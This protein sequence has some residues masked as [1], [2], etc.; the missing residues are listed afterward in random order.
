MVRESTAGTAERCVRILVEVRWEVLNRG[1]DLRTGSVGVGLGWV[2]LVN[3]LKRIISLGLHCVF[4][5]SPRT[6]II[7][8]DIDLKQLFILYLLQHRPKKFSKIKKS[9]PSIFKPRNE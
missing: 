5:I 2:G 1:R 6:S 8:L 7:A 9:V 3:G 4:I